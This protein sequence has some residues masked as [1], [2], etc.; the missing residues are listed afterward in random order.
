MS[1][2]KQNSNT[3]KIVIIFQTWPLFFVLLWVYYI[4]E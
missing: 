3:A 2:F 4:I 1:I